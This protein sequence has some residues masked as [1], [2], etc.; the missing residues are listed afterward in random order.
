M[1]WV[2]LERSELTAVCACGEALSGRSRVWCA[3]CVVKN[4]PGSSQ[5]PFCLEWYYT[6]GGNIKES[7]LSFHAK[8]HCKRT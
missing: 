4:H 3:Q 8:K 2:T 1:A 6:H 5:C 7:I